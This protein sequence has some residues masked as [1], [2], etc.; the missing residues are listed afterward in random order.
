VRVA[1][2]GLGRMG[3]PMARRLLEAGHEL[4]VWNRSPGKAG[5]LTA[6]GA[7]E[8][9]SP[10]DLAAGAE[11]VVTMVA[12]ADA[13]GDVLHGGDG[14]LAGLEPGA[15]VIDMSTIGPIAAR[16]FAAEV[17]AAGGTWLDAPVSGSTALAQQGTLTTMVGG[18]AGALERAR[19][20]L[21]AMTA[22]L[23][24]MGAAGTGAAM[25]VVV[26]TALAQLNEAVAEGIVLAER[27]GIARE[28]A[29]DVLAGGVVGAPF[30][31]YKRDAFVNP[32]ETPVAFTVGLMR[33]DLGLAFSLADEAGVTLPSATAADG[34]LER[35]VERGLADADMARVADVV[36]EG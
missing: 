13:L 30:V 15:I 4:T 17:E 27:A 36:R 10:K 16:G 19:P 8:A 12:H 31:Q 6:A 25:K 34:V 7:K 1:F 20:V 24:H 18:D 22:K 14:L 9:G 26:Q 2:A 5:D 29:Y 21:E 33:K 32:E 23:F 35:A 11:V 3:V 28:A